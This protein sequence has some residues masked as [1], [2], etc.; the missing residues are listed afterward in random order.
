MPFE[1]M[2]LALPEVIL[3]APRLFP[4]DRGFFMEV[5]KHSDFLKAG[6][7]EHFVQDNHSQSSLAVL[8]GL[9]Y[10][11]D[12]A[13]QG[14]LVRCLRGKIYDV[15]VDIRKGSPRYGKWVSAELSGEN[16]HQLYVPPGFAHGFVVLTH[17]AEIMYK[18]TEEYSPENDRGIRWND[19]DINV[20]WPVQE[21]ILSEKDKRHPSLRDADN[22]FLFRAA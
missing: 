8:R 4:D 10:Q 1:F 21:P 20:I 18:C 13:A 6:I 15:A 19:P 12:P 22:N 11:K 5:Y 17:T 9:H 3:I 7:P 16:N 2:R 14:K